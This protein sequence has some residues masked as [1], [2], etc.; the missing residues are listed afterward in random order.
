MR[1]KGQWF[2][3]IGDVGD[4]SQGHAEKW[5]NKCDE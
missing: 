2:A 1:L 5:C 3:G 4:V